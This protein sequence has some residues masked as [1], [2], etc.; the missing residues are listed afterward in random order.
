MTNKTT[1]GMKK[2]CAV[3]LC[4]MMTLSLVA[5]S[6]E[7]DKQPESSGASSQSEMSTKTTMTYGKVS[8]VT[9]NEIEFSLAKDPFGG[10]EVESSSGTE[11]GGMAAATLTEAVEGGD[12]AAQEAPKMDLEYTGESESYTI[13]AG[14]KII[15]I[16]G[17]EEQLSAI[18]K[19]SVL[20]ITKD[21][22]TGAVTTIN[23]FE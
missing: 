4:G 15:G 23:I 3:V 19:G 12:G 6:T 22:A 8:S 21:D 13:P 14:V 18:K 10:D 20:A 11:G 16:N 1:K 5:C 7:P 9:G 2:I 17:N